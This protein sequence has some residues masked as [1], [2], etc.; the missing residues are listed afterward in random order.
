MQR[1]LITGSNGLLGQKLLKLLLSQPHITPIATS[2]GENRITSVS[3]FQYVSMDI[4]CQEQ[5]ENVI[6]T[7][8]PD[9]I[10]HTAAMTRV[11]D[12]ENNRQK[13][14]EVN[15]M[16]SQHLI[17]AAEKINAFFLYIS[18]D[19]VFDGIGKGMYKE[20]DS[21]NPP[22]Y[23]GETKLEAEKL[24]INTTL[25]WAIART[26]LVY[27]IAEDM[28]RSNII[29]WVKRSLEN[30]KSIQVVEDQ[31]RTPTLVEDLAKGCLAIVNKKVQG[32]FHISGKDFLSPYQM[33]LETATF[34][35]LD[36]KLISPTDA[37][38]FKEVGKRPPKTGFNIEKAQS[39]LNFK[40]VS[41]KE[42]LQVLSSQLNSQ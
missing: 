36:T 42:G 4:T 20:E 25:S 41:F 14:H 5:V 13:A 7:H 6:L 12:C 10:I 16:G 31:W 30:N 8:E 24:L 2:R 3:N 29:L 28:S 40:P 33:A 35:G 19:F 1:V 23:Y 17:H 11:E 26:V 37:S 39:V 38:K 18:T 9:I 15:V 22:N 32:V 21:T 34:F 27:G